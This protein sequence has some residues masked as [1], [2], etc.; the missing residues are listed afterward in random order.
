MRIHFLVPH[1]RDYAPGQRLKF[2]QYYDA[3][4]QVGFE[5]IHDGFYTHDLYF[6]RLSE[7]G[8]AGKLLRLGWACLKRLRSLWTAWRSDVVYVF[9][10]AVPAGPPV[11]E[12]IIRRVFRRPMVYDIDDLIYLDK[13]GSRDPFPTLFEPKKKVAALMRMADH[14]IVCTP[15]L[16]KVARGLNERVTRISSTIDTVKYRPK[17]R[18][19]T[20]RVTLGW[21]GSFSTSSYLRLLDDVL[22][23]L[24]QRHGAA[25]R[26][27]GDSGFQIPG[28][29]IDARPWVLDTE[30]ADLLAIDIGLY[31]LRGVEWDLGKSGLKALQYMGLGIPAVLTPFGANLEIVVHGENGFFADTAEEW[32]EMVTRLIQD[33]GLRERIGRAGRRTVEERYSVAVNWPLYRGAVE[34]AMAMGRRSR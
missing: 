28:I 18:Y 8:L 21:S 34:D 14:V 31:P 20:T 27:I 22:R 12:W 29:E 33:V 15:H 26:V 24:Q 25:I 7:P 4:R 30:V 16:E 32:I 11:L 19:E 13:P 17:A 2:E 1:G 6:R 23:V 3:F 5:V 9:L 10:A